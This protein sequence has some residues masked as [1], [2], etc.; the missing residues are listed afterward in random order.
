MMQK[1]ILK[2]VMAE[3]F[4]SFANRVVFTCVADESKKEYQMNTF[5]AGEDTINKVSYVY[6]A[7]GSGKTFFCKILREFQKMILLSPLYTIKDLQTGVLSKEF[8]K[9]IPYFIF[10]IEH[11]EI[12]ITLGA[13]F[14]I[15]DVTYHYEFSILK[16]K[17]I[18]ELLT[19]KY[20]RTEKI[21][22]R[23]SPNY[24]DITL[25]SELKSFES[26]KN[27][28]KE[29]MLCLTM[30]FVLN[31]EL[32]NTLVDA[33][34]EIKILNIAVPHLGARNPEAFSK[35]RIQKYVKILQKADPTI[36][37]IQVQ[38]KEEEVLRQKLKSDDFENKEVIRTKTT[39][40]VKSKHALYQDGIEIDTVADQIDFFEDESL[41]TIK[42]FTTLPYLF[43]V[44]ENGGVLIL[45]EIE[46]GLHLSLVKEMISLFINEESNPHHAQ[47]I[48]T[49]HQPLLVSE[50][51]KRDQV[52][53]LSKDKFGK[54]VIN[55]LSDK[56]FSRAKVNL[57]NQLLEGVFGCN[58]EKIF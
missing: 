42:L 8:K 50:N 5:Q 53:I 1:I 21:L 27:V 49:T 37:E 35:E 3:N 18:H 48:C 38:C 2:S 4:A 36:R 58:P 16:Q 54:S 45:D 22:E 13:D 15:E 17:I 55:R 19:R 23:T 6:G 31:N 33:I 24:Q 57:T 14:I 10:D 11:E 43:D 29:N 46:N 52:W 30:A 39:V 20:R 12:P 25:K 56:S 51:V 26:M 40:E 47:L 7:N 28:V 44:L 41:G 32:A 34:K 9:Q